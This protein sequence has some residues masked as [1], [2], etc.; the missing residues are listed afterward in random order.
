M[1]LKDVIV[2]IVGKNYKPAHAAS[3]L[4]SFWALSCL[5]LSNAT[6]RFN[7]VL[8]QLWSE[9]LFERSGRIYYNPSWSSLLDTVFLSPFLSYLATWVLREVNHNTQDKTANYIPAPP[10]RHFKGVC[11]G[12][13]ISVGEASILTVRVSLM[14]SD[15]SRSVY[16]LGQ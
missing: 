2:G 16:G 7:H 11:T 4:N 6:Q 5:H 14:S 1:C 15:N 9:G 12:C 13:S 10:S 8:A 3:V